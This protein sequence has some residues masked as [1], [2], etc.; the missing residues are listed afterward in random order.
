MCH[1]NKL[2]QIAKLIPRGALAHIFCGPQHCR[3][4]LRSYWK[5]EIERF[6]R[7][8]YNGR[9]KYANLP[10]NMDSSMVES[11]IDDGDNS[12]YFSP[13]PAVVS[14]ACDAS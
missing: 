11:V 5:S 8:R 2:M 7:H 3:P 9:A 13:A 4:Q 12:D 10:A 6:C 14:V 1:V